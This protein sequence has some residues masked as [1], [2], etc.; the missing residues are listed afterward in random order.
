MAAEF[1]QCR[2]GF[3]KQAHLAEGENKAAAALRELRQST[4]KVPDLTSE[5]VEFQQAEPCSMYTIDTTAMFGQ[6]VCG[7]PKD[8]HFAKAENKAAIARA[9]L[10]VKEQQALQQ[11]SRKSNAQV[12]K[13]SAGQQVRCRSTGDESWLIGTVTSID[14]ANV[15][16]Q[17]QEWPD[18]HLW[19]EIGAIQ[20]PCSDFKVDTKSQ[21][22]GMCICGYS[23]SAHKAK[24][25][26]AAEAALLAMKARNSQKAAQQE[27]E[28]KV[29]NEI[30]SIQAV[31]KAAE[32]RAT[33]EIPKRHDWGMGVGTC[34]LC[35]SYC[36][37]RGCRETNRHLC[38]K[39]WP[40][41]AV[42]GRRSTLS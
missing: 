21:E 4:Q 40:T 19:D 22:F 23:Q 2:C 11:L 39:C 25:I 26:N 37:N 12:G 33:E 31:Q 38:H 20:G 10:A 15:L 32:E 14:G 34:A 28:Q 9:K 42:E 3:P 5:K 16:V 30:V 36:R 35:N 7:H 13:F 29:A 1:G 6:C 27:G 24:S 17:P 8:K 18:S 41:Y